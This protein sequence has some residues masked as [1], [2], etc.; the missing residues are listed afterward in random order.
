MRGTRPVAALTMIVG[1][2]ALAACIPVP[3]SAPDL[4]RFENVVVYSGLQQPTVLAF[5]PDGR[6]FVGEKSGIVKV[7][8]NLADTTPTTFADLR[9]S[10]HNFWDRGL[11]G[12]TV[13]PQFPTRPYVYV[14]YTYDAPIGG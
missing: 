1:C 13:D 14:S 2:V 11:L 4:A 7:F 12:L 8:D 6:V 5:A 3:G 10:V 9:T